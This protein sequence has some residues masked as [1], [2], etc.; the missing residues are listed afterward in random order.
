M[1]TIYL[2]QVTDAVYELMGCHKAGNV[3]RHFVDEV[4]SNV[5]VDKDGV[6]TKDWFLA[7]FTRIDVIFYH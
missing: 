2:G 4:F 1:T 6:V 7:F 5:D 3:K